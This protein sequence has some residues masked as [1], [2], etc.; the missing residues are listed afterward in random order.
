MRLSLFM[1]IIVIGFSVF[2]LQVALGQPNPS[3]P[4]TQAENNRYVAN[5][6]AIIRDA[7]PKGWMYYPGNRV[8]FLRREQQVIVEERYHLKDSLVDE[9]WLKLRD[10]NGNLLGWA[11]NGTLSSGERYLVPQVPPL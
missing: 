4:P 7:P 11:Y 1:L 5:Y 8:G 3:A 6:D 2:G 10:E 9:E